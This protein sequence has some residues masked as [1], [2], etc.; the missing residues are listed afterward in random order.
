MKEH[1][2]L[3]IQVTGGGSGVG[4]AALINGGTDICNASEA[5]ETS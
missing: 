3:T 4:I 2:G 5:Y 1:P